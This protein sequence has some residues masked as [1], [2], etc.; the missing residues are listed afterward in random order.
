VHY[1]SPLFTENPGK[2]RPGPTRDEVDKMHAVSRIMLHGWI[3]NIQ[4][5]W[6]KLG[7]ERAQEMLNIGVNDFVVT[8]WALFRP[9]RQWTKVM[10]GSTKP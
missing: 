3:D 1:D 4:T 9:M 7:P 8:G 5:S 10:R 2:V 6:T